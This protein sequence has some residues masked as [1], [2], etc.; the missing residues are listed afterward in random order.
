MKMNELDK[1]REAYENTRLRPRGVRRAPDP[2]NSGMRCVVP[3]ADRKATAATDGTMK[4]FVRD[5][6]VRV[7]D[8]CRGEGLIAGGDIPDFVVEVP[9]NK[10]HGDL[11]TN[12]AM[13]LARAEKRPPRDIAA[14]LAARLHAAD[15]RIDDVQVAGPGFIN[16]CVRE[17]VWQTV[18]RDIE[19]AGE[20]Y[21]AV[22]I[23][24]GDRVM[25]EF[26]SANPTG[27]LH[28]GH[29][30]GA[31]LGDVLARILAFTGYAVQR[32]YYIN[33]VGVQMHNLGRATYLRYLELLNRP[34]EFPEGLYRGA[35]IYD[36][37]REVLASEGER[38]AHM[39]PAEA[40]PFF[41]AFASARILRGIQDDLNAFGVHF[42]EWFSEKQLF[43]RGDVQR[44]I[45]EL[46]ARDLAY[47]Q[48]GAVWFRATRYGD[49]KDRVM[50]KEDGATTYFASDISYHR[51]KFARGFYR[52]IDIWGADHHGYVP[53]IR[54]V[55]QALGLEEDRF[56]V[57][58]VQMVNLLRG[59]V[60]VAMSTRSGEFV[61]L[62][63]VIDEVGRDAARFMFMT[64]R[65]DAQLDF[66]LE[67][68]K[69]QSDDNP[70]YYVQYAH[71]RICSIIG[72]AAEKGY[73]LPPFASVRVEL[74]AAP[75]EVDLMKKLLQFPETVAGSARALEPHRIAVY[76][77]E[78]VG[79]F[80]SYY[81]KHRV[82]TD[83]PELSRARLH[84]MGAV[85][86]VLRNGLSLLGVKAPDAM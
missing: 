52:V 41:T 54:A 43:E 19:Q 13:V 81:S 40:V 15:P 44:A 80:H 14:L 71:A 77:M 39:D 73:A 35:Y 21:G 46:R 69:K 82:I 70:V 7:L 34:V 12:L 2:G 42:Q 68:A 84:L 5:A 27:P 75:E 53:R 49:E 16:F 86:T 59:G 3:G 37:A 1:L 45:D 61:T 25:V 79:Q 58:L 36:V 33:D 29:G 20:R 51:N 26:V 67:V 47:E 66:D 50:I 9:R 55:L 17:D 23:G 83:Q 24:R 60:P 56:R 22:D 38:F 30:R 32:E 48:D 64:R 74:L 85:R 10:V 4:E 31:A 8:E 62:R 72:F 18:L 63:E 28:I 65:S 6:L 57:L 78:L 11:A 76:L